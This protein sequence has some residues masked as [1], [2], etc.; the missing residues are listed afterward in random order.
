MTHSA[1]SSGDSVPLFSFLEPHAIVGECH[2]R[3]N[4]D[5]T[6]SAICVE[7]EPEWL[8]RHHGHESS[9]KNGVPA[10][11]SIYVQAKGSCNEAWV[12]RRSRFTAIS[13]G[14]EGWFC[15]SPENRRHN[16]SAICCGA[17][18]IGYLSPRCFGRDTRGSG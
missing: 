18:I 13:I 5:E 7:Q 12:P 11:L 3:G 14:S 6:Y 2:M 10:G 15:I 17:A 8:A 1:V 4:E 16:P 9:E